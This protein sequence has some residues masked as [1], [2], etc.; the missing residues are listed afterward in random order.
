MNL[1]VKALLASAA[2]LLA[3]ESQAQTHVVAPRRGK[4]QPRRQVATTEMVKDGTTMKEGRLYF[5]ELGHTAPLE[6]DKKLLNGTVITKDGKITR[7]DGTTEQ[8]K[9]GD[10]VSLTGRLTTRRSMI[11]EDSVRK[12][13]AFDLKH[14]GKRA[15]ME[16]AREKAEK[17]KAKLEKERAKLLAEQAKK[18]A[19]KG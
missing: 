2:L 3:H 15:E 18:K 9:E 1:L 11:A 10:Q 16:K 13:V 5:T 19:K 17:A 8:I 7:S 4:V 6:Q 14:P 12:L